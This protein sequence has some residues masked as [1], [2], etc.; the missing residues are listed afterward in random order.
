[1]IER[2]MLHLE[3]PMEFSV[4]SFHRF[5]LGGVRPT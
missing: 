1:M 5:E 4:Q 3:Q 2:L